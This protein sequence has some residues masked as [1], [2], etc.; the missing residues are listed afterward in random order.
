MQNNQTERYFLF[1][2]PSLYPFAR[3]LFGTLHH[4][5]RMA[6]STTNPNAEPE[7]F[8]SAEVAG[9]GASNLVEAPAPAN[10]PSKARKSKKGAEPGVVLDEG[11]T[12]ATATDNLPTAEAGSPTAAPADRLDQIFEGLKQKSTAKQAIFRNT[13]AAFDCLRLVTQ[14][15][16]VELA[17]KLTSL[18]ASVVIEY[19]PINEMEYHIKFSGDLLV[20]VMHSNVVTFADDYGPMS[21]TYVN[22]DFRRRF[23][24]HIMAYNFMADSIK[25][26]RLN[27]PGYLVGRL[28]VN[29]DNHY[30]LE[31]VQQLELPN[32]DMSDNK[33]TTDAMRLFVESAMIA[34]VNNDL[35]AP[36]LP[37]IQR[38]SVKQKLENQQVS[39]GSKVGF[40]FSAQQAI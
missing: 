10:K 34:A 12:G 8:T 13:Q 15:L 18:D 2:L 25:Y 1:C 19:R 9:S 36:P 32:N 22:E 29:I 20:F 30:Y 17:R 14:E 26:Q 4:L 31:G 33:I 16:V 35:I 24:G 39:R 7:L 27:D 6:K 40:S 21:S 11:H 5:H 28:L 38:I 37:E 23:F 3:L